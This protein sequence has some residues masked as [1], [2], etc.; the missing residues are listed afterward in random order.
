M[1]RPLMSNKLTFPGQPGDLVER[2][3]CSFL[4]GD[5]QFLRLLRPRQGTIT[6]VTATLLHKFVNALKL[7]GITDNSRCND[8]TTALNGCSIHL[9]VGLASAEFGRKA[10]ITNDG[11]GTASVHPNPA[12]APLKHSSDEVGYK[13]RV[14]TRRGGAAHKDSEGKKTVSDSA[15]TGLV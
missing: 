9:P 5:L 7:Y 10:V 6:T 13:R 11:G 2:H 1:E 15:K 8:L 14:T 3:H 4:E 12:G